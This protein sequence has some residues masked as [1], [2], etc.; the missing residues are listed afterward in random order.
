LEQAN[1]PRTPFAPTT[2]FALVTNSPHSLLLITFKIFS[3]IFQTKFW[4]IKK[5]LLKKT[6][7]KTLLKKT[8]KKTYKKRRDGVYTGLS[9]MLG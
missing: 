6:Y 3:C 4:P 9:I 1:S 7:K 5:N 2:T 8:Y